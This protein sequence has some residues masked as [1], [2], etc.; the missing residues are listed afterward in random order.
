MKIVIRKS[1]KKVCA[2]TDKQNSLLLT[3]V[4][5]AFGG[6][7]SDYIEQEVDD[8]G[9]KAAL[10]EDPVEKVKTLQKSKQSDID[11]NLPSWQI[12]SDAIDTAFTGSQ[13]VVIKKLAK[14]IYWLAKNKE[15]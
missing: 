1:D 15:D 13:R 11:T 3:H 14:V 12:V 8:D 10:A 7:E 4:L 9:Y 5:I 6:E 2:S